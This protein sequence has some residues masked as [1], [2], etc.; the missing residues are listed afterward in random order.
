MQ[1]KTKARCCGVAVLR[2]TVAQLHSH[3]VAL[4]A[5]LV[6]EFKLNVNQVNN[7]AQAGKI[8]SPLESGSMY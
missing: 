1:S 2:C 3:T 8:T 5:V 6:L 7:A 4:V